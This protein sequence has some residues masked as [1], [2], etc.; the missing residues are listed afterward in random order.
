MDYKDYYKILGVGKNASS[1][2]IKKAYRKLARQYH[3]D[4]NPGDQ[5]A[6]NKFKD[7][8]EAYEVLSDDDKRQKYDR[9][10]SE[11][12][13]FE[14]AGGSPNDF[15]WGQWA[16]AGSPGGG[17]TRTVSPEEFEQMF[18]GG[19]G[20]GGFS[21]FFETLFGRGRSGGSGGGFG[22]NQGAGSARTSRGQDMEQE[23]EITLEEALHGTTRSMQ[24][25]DGRSFTAR[26]PP[27]VKTGS[28]VRLSGKGQPGM[29]GQAGDLFLKIKVQPHG[30]LQRK[31]D[32]LYV[33]VP[34]DLFTAMLGGKTEV[35][36][37][38]RTVNLTIPPETANDKKFRLSGLGMPRLR[39]PG[40]RGDLYARVKI[41]L[42]QNLSEEEKKL[43][44][45]WQSIRR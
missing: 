29:G 17:Y 30:R 3:P 8:N 38:D 22:F 16:S 27:G 14:R 34:V 43:L 45:Q 15:N 32:N 25:S 2:E 7:I 23:V 35:M 13:Q 39:K 33:D 41:I 20:A 11:W 19:G 1:S 44:S 42:P 6:E 40:E 36:G 10:G 5:T 12:R 4:V 31:G 9:F 37:L 21:D 18:G 24:Y 26:I 28:K